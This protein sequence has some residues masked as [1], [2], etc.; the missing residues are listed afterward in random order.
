MA[1]EICVAKR[2]NGTRC[3]SKVLP[4]SNFCAVHKLKSVFERSVLKRIESVVQYIG[5][6][7][8]R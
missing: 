8:Y 3:T 2:G 5:P 6:T 7:K 1:E 4:F